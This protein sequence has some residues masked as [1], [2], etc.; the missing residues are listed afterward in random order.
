MLFDFLKYI[1]PTWYFNLTPE[2]Q[3]I[4][5]FVDYRKLESVERQLLD[6]DDKYRTK[7]GMLA[8]AAYQ[9][10][11]KGIMKTEPDYSL[12]L[13]AK[14]QKPDKQRNLD[15]FESKTIRIN[16]QV[17]ATDINDNYRFIRRFF[18]PAISW[19]IL[20]V[21]LFSFHNPA[22][23]LYGFIRSQ[24]IERV[25]LYQ[26]NSWSLFKDE[27]DLF[28]SFLIKQQPKVSVIIPTLNRYS[29]LKD[30]LS[31]LEQQDYRN[32]EVIVCDQSDKLEQE[33]Y[34]EWKLDLKLIRQE[35]KALWLA[36]NTSIRNAEGEYILLFDDDS[37]VK[38]DWITQHLRCLN[39]FNT[40]ISS[41]VSLSVVGSKI[42]EN[43][44][45]FRWS[46]QIDTGNVMFKKEM[47]KITGMFDRQFER[48]RQGDGEFGLRCFLLGLRNV[49]NPLAGRIHLKV[50]E[51]GLR[52]MGS[53]DGLR[54]K[55]IF[56]PRPVP[57][58]LY[59]SR[60][61][62]GDHLSR[63]MLLFSIPSSVV[64]YKYKSKERLKIAVGISLIMIWPILLL[65]VFLSWSKAA[66]KLNS[67]HLIEKL[68][69]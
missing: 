6:L 13:T 69:G 39:Y 3:S 62:F 10:W 16:E 21:R 65:Q 60:K 33:F 46:D 45:F 36:R 11:H 63:L 55:K 35:E 30:A 53:W 17:F 43:Y 38:P 56:G 41:G 68:E 22:K 18:N 47:M 20:L 4:S 28:D 44:S 50:T 15:L 2:G 42:P 29:Y 67:G 9:A 58:V 54:P 24:K 7:E 34:K 61:Y 25:D 26:T 51:G 48:Q 27:Y 32:F 23:E 19:Y 31:D 1:S 14:C 57:S 52:Q 64:P 12:F 40:D 5:Y 49:S 8:D 59:L 66:D 37:R